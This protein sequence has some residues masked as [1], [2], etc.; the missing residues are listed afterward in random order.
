MMNRLS[1]ARCSARRPPRESRRLMHALAGALLACLSIFAMGARQADQPVPSERDPSLEAQAVD[2]PSPAG[3]FPS[4]IVIQEE[5]LSPDDSMQR[6]RDT[7]GRR[8]GRSERRLTD[9]TVELI[10]RFGRFCV[11]PLPPGLQP[12]IG[13]D[14]TLAARCASP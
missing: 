8:A 1:G 11:K 6:L 12:G 5:E 14:T 2:Q 7:L 4:P 3:E 13:G 10:T 9:G